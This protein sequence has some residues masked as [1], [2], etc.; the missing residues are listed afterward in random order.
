MTKEQHEVLANL[1]QGAVDGSYNIVGV[2]YPYLPAPRRLR[3]GVCLKVT[4][5]QYEAMAGMNM[6]YIYVYDEEG[7]TFEW[8]VRTA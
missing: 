2:E 8:H 5:V 7:R 3:D 6:R 1:A 4:T